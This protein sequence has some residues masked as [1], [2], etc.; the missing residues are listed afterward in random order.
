M[1]QWVRDNVRLVTGVLSVVALALVFGA[2]GGAIPSTVVPHPGETVL[3]AIPHLNAVISATA[4]VTIGLGWRTI[5]RGE[6]AR[7]RALMGTSFALFATF[8][9]FYLWRLVIRGTA[10]FPGPDAVYQFVYLPFLTVHI[11]L[12]VVCIPFVFH[13]LT[14]AA[15]HSPRELYDT[16]HARSGRIAASLWVISFAMGIGVYVMLHHLF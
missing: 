12:A 4:I 10:E 13:A 1:R 3:D 8:L 11:L 5:R 9:V 6:V 2:A 14:L 16:A 15:T 7:H